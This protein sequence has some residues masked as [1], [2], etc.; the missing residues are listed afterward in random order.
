MPKPK[1][2]ELS[3]RED[4]V[5]E[6]YQYMKKINKIGDKLFNLYYIDVDKAS[7]LSPMMRGMVPTYYVDPNN[8][9]HP[10]AYILAGTSSIPYLERMVFVTPF[11]NGKGKYELDLSAWK[12]LLVKPDEFN[13]KTKDFRKT[14]LEPMVIMGERFGGERYNQSLILRESN[15]PAKQ[16]LVLPFLQLPSRKSEGEEAY[17]AGLNELIYKP[18]YQYLPDYIYRKLNFVGIPQDTLDELCE[19]DVADLETDDGDIVT[20]TKSLFPCI[21]KDQRFSIA[22]V[23]EPNIDTSEGRFHYIVQ[24]E[25]VN[26]IGVASIIIFTLLAALQMTEEYQ[27]GE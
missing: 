14:K 6:Q 5:I 1:V 15:T 7:E 24:E 17:Q 16:E 13:T 27:E 3:S 21:S 10:G 4:F 23:M 9:E 22:K 26:E 2:N 25:M 11:V 8:P 18:F 19:N 12:G 20:V